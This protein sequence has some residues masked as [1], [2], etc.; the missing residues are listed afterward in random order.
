MNWM[1]EYRE[2][3]LPI[4]EAVKV[5]KSG[6][7]VYIGTSSSTAYALTDALYQRRDEL[8]N[9]TICSGLILR[10]L[11]VFKPEAKGHF[12]NST[13]FAGPGER[14]GMKNGLTS[15]TS[16][17]LSQVN[18]WC[19]ETAR[20]NIAFLEVSPPDDDGYMSYGAYGVAFHDCV[21]ETADKVVL[22][23]NRSVPYVYGEKNLIH[24]S[25]A[26]IVT[27][28]D[29]ELAEVPNL[30]FDDTVRTMS[31]LIVERIPDGATLQLGLGGI[32]NAVGFGL[33]NKNDLGIHTEM[34]TCSMMALTKKGV[35]TNKY[36]NFM[37]GK[38]V[39]AFALGTRELYDF[40]DHNEGIHFTPYSIV[41]DPVVIA[42]NDNMISVNTAMSVDLYGQVAAD[43]LGGKQQSAVGGQVDYVRGS[44]MSKGGKSFIALPS[45][46]SGKSGTSSRIVAAFPS[47]TAV[48]T[49]RSDVQYV[50]TEYGC[51]NLKP[52]TMDDRARALISLAHPDFR[53]EL[54]EGAKKLGIL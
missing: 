39:T 18:L 20:A 9:V 50:V 41:N 44:Q 47:G 24:I 48:T 31:G 49:A 26:D 43:S 30:P 1:K 33:E 2:K 22:Q 13:Y 27:E 19:R 8:E 12:R 15:Y 28:C 46:I 37:P 10:Q 40:V 29:D 25:Q 51:V 35:I 11:D 14:T 21:R 5:V 4:D 32:S 3:L 52:L 16:F 36:K 42:R 53:D 38:S 54:A 45:T 34:F 7:R 23:V 17:H 6:D